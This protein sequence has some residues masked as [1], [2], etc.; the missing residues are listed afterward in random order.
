MTVLPNICIDTRISICSQISKENK[1]MTLKVAFLPLV[2]NKTHSNVL[3][4]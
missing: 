4:I 1:K 2:V 3:Y